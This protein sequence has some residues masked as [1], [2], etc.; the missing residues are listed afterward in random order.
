M[1]RTDMDTDTHEERRKEDE[2]FITF[3]KLTA[4]G[5]Y[6]RV[7]PSSLPPSRI[8]QFRDDTCLDDVYNYSL[9]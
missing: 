5:K 2:A 8:E 9:R 1:R 7:E 4:E 6:A 3:L